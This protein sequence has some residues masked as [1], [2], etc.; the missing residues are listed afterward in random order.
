MYVNEDGTWSHIAECH[1]SWPCYCACYLCQVH[2]HS[3]RTEQNETSN[4]IV[5]K[6]KKENSHNYSISPECTKQISAIIALWN[7]RKE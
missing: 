3:A 1:I 6:E 2:A 7:S 4:I 5:R